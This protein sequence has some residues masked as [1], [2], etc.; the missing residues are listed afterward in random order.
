MIRQQTMQHRTIVN[1]FSFSGMWPPSAKRGI[2]KM[3]SYQ[4]KKRTIND[5][6]DNVED[7]SIELL[8]L[9]PTRPQE[10]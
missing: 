3:W 4:K 6:E 1:S 5:V 8:A 9:P 10:I 2:K 7:D